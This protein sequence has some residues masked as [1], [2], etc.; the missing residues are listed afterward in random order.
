VETRI[1]ESAQGGNGKK[2]PINVPLE[3]AGQLQTSRFFVLHIEE[4]SGLLMLIREEKHSNQHFESGID[5]ADTR[6]CSQLLLYFRGGVAKLQMTLEGQSTDPCAPIEPYWCSAITNKQHIDLYE[7]MINKSL[8]A[9]LRNSR[10]YQ[11]RRKRLNCKTR[12]SD[13]DA[14]SMMMKSWTRRERD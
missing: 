13:P 4:E 12:C 14:F 1:N 5:E 10:H 2:P 6:K 11:L 9:I 7:K 8:S 3:Q